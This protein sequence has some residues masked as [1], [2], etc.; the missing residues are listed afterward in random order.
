[1][2]NDA[3]RLDTMLRR[4][5]A[6][7]KIR[8][9]GTPGFFL[10]I[11]T[12]TVNGRFLL[13]HKRYMGDIL[14]RAGMIDCK[15]L[16]TPAAVSQ[17]VSPSSQSY[18]NPTQYR[19]IVGALQYLTITHPDLSYAV[20]QLCQFMHFPTDEHCALVKRVLWYVKGTLDYGLP[21]GLAVPIDRKSTSRYAVF[22]GNNLISWLSR[23]QRTVGRRQL[24]L[25]TRH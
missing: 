14:N 23:K 2:G 10:G 8:D 20:N 1:M 11:E 17:V 19:R 6:T 15:P 7:F 9:L 3:A 5:S 22:L 21:I 25:N 18:E 16:A 24:R 4:L 13:S 12:L